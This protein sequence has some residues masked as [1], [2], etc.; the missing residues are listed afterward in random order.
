MNNPTDNHPAGSSVSHRTRSGQTDTKEQ[1]VVPLSDPGKPGS[2]EVSSINGSIHV[3]GYSGK[4]VMIDAVSHRP[5]KQPD[6]GPDESG[7][8]RISTGNALDMS[9]EEKNN[10]VRVNPNTI[11][12]PVD[13]TIKVP[14]RFSLKLTRSITATLRSRM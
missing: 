10:R 14:Q 6:R 5:E 9:A 12:Q 2:L 11:H 13:L 3:I 8:R 7:M 1:L 4:D